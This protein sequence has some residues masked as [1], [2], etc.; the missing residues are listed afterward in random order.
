[1]HQ[2]SYRPL[3]YRDLLQAMNIEEEE[4]ARFSRIMGMLEKEGEIVRT[5]RDK[6][7]IPEKMNLIRGVISLNQRGYGI[8]TPDDPNLSEI[9][10]YG[11]NL[12]GAMHQDKV[13]ARIYQR[14]GGGMRPEG[15][16]IR[17]L[18]RANK[19]LVGRLEKGRQ[20][21]QVIPDDS[22]QIYPINVKVPP[23]MK[24]KNCDKVLV[25][26]TRWPDKDKHPEG[27]IIEVLGSKGQP[28]LDVLV[29]IK[30]HGLEEKFP[31]AVIE[32]ARKKAQPVKD[33]DLKG[34]LDLRQLKMVT[35]DGEDAKDLDDA[36]SIEKTGQGY[37]LGVH[38]ADVSHYVTEGSRLDKE[39][40]ARATSVYLVE[41]VLPMLP[42]ELSNDIC[43]L[44]VRE[45]RLA[46]SCI[47]DINN[48][49]Q[50]IDYRLAK[51]VINVRERMTYTAVNNILVAQ[52]AE[53]K[54]RYRELVPD[55]HLMQEL[56]QILRAERLQRGALDF[57]FPEAKV[58]V[59]E[60]SVP[61][62]IK[63]VERGPGEMLIEDFMIKA[64]EVVAEHVFRQEIPI[65]F[66]V[67]AKPDSEA[68]AKLNH[69]LA[70]FGLKFDAE[71]IEPKVFQKVLAQIK[72]H[73][74][75]KTISLTMLRSMKHARYISQALGHFGLASKY[76]CHFTSPIR[77]YPDLIVHRILKDMLEG[78]MNKKKVE[79]L[80]QILPP[81]GEHATLKEI[82][83]EEAERDLLDIKKAQYMHQFVGE[84]FSARI[85]SVLAFGFFVEL[86]NTVE[87]LVHISSIE[88]DYYEFNDQTLSLIGTHRGRKF[89]IGDQVR[90]LLSRVDVEDAKI[91]FE[92]IDKG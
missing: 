42:P 92:L 69:V 34:R 25:E 66:R 81:Q 67:H 22:R 75:E 76:Y 15:E 73:P 7:G 6:F 23:K 84:E 3:S 30:K 90:V 24:V 79:K 4:F 80:H 41:K 12:N 9:F 40:S 78:K 72:G 70:I 52:D 19:R 87:G 58:I 48:R 82:K 62:E 45:D 21:T 77:R 53:T 64:N 89:A 61:I 55:F 65:L 17:A 28:G 54:K 29:I 91:D 51:S 56:A 37:K 36:V 71:K 20:S 46:M 10:I 33:Q 44:N 59:D 38:I 88:D 26:I 43:S 16:V 47:M 74:G 85:S 31:A 8:L 63:R 32:E 27:K 49:G 86:E 60:N 18:N 35:I 13:M 83:A 68:V 39:A 14:N 57:D 5:R 11:R 50:V 2:T 1:M